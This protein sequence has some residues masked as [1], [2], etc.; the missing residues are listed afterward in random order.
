MRHKLGATDSNAYTGQGHLSSSVYMRRRL[1][2]HTMPPSADCSAPASVAGPAE[3]LPFAATQPW[4]S[5]SGGGC[6]AD[7]AASAASRARTG[8]SPSRRY[9]AGMS[10]CSAAQPGK[11]VLFSLFLAF[12]TPVGHLKA[13]QA[14]P[15]TA[16]AISLLFNPACSS[17]YSH[18]YMHAAQTIPPWKAN[19]MERTLTCMSA[20][21]TWCTSG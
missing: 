5:A 11:R 6:A 2:V 3:E 12:N 17:C 13:T 1:G 15:N 7:A 4:P 16:Q 21:K 19:Y 10:S 14:W 18:T 9:S 20:T 8:A